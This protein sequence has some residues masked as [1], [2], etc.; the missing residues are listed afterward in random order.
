MHPKI[1]VYWVNNRNVKRHSMPVNAIE[2]HLY[3]SS[4]ILL[5]CR[6]QGINTVVFVNPLLM[7]KAYYQGS[8]DVFTL[9]DT[10]I[11]DPEVYELRRW[12]VTWGKMKFKNKQ[13][14]NAAG[15]S[16]SIINF[17]R[18]SSI[19]LDGNHLERVMA[20]MR[21]AYN[22][23]KDYLVTDYPPPAI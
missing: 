10:V 20:G 16:K 12:E 11:D 9:K 3:N 17:Y 21:Q 7:Y 2:I 6:A 13:I 1:K 8:C 18:G 4:D 15:D 19:N 23:G 5:E 22:E 14:L